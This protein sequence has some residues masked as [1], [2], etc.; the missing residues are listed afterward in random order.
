MGP[1]PQRSVSIGEGLDGRRHGRAR[2]LHEPLLGHAERLGASVGTG[3]RLGPDGREGRTRG[4]PTTQS[5]KVGFEDRGIVGGQRWQVG[6][7][8]PIRRDGCRGHRGPSVSASADP[9]GVRTAAAAPAVDRRS[10]VSSSSDAIDRHRARGRA[11]PGV[12]VRPDVVVERDPGIAIGCSQSIQDPAAQPAIGRGEGG[13]AFTGGSG[14]RCRGVG[15]TRVDRLGR[16]AAPRLCRTG[17]ATRRAWLA[18]GRPHIHHGVRPGAGLIDRDGGVGNGLDVMGGQIRGRG[19]RHDPA[20]HAPDVDVDRTDRHAVGERGDGTGRVRTDPGQR[21][22]LGDAGRD[23]AAVLLDDD[24]CGPPQ[25]EGPPVVAETGPSAQDVG[26]GGVGEGLHGRE[27][28]HEPLPVLGS[29]GGLGL[30]GHRLRHED[31]VRIGRAPEGERPAALRVPGEDGVARLE[32][33]LGDSGHEV[34]DNGGCRSR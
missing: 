21:L 23:V 17:L 29:A 10:A 28:G 24:A 1:V 5:A 22:E 2:V 34:E 15:V 16:E 6:R 26:W 11:H 4:P 20:E 33:D 32:R 8:A 9:G 30:L 25:R 13:R 12:V 19:A 18:H 14:G 27:A 7:L 3:H 31:R